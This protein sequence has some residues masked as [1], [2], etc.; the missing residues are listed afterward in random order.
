LAVRWVLAGIAAFGV[1]VTVWL[2]TILLIVLLFVLARWDAAQW[3][4]FV[5]PLAIGL[6]VWVARFAFYRVLNR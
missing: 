5:L 3:G 1:F 6:G 2:G 4:W